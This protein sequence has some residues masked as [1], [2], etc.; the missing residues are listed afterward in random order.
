MK[1]YTGHGRGRLHRLLDQP[2]L[3][4]TWV[5]GPFGG[6][7]IERRMD[8]GLIKKRYEPVLYLYIFLYIYTHTR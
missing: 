3:G 6:G 7:S 4:D 5:R 2:P 1:E 8:L